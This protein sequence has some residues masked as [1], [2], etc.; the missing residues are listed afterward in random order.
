MK[1]TDLI[2]S[3]GSNVRVAS[4]WIT[5]P[6]AN[7][8]RVAIN[9]FQQFI[10]NVEIPFGKDTGK[11]QESQQE[12]QI[13]GESAHTA[14]TTPAS[15]DNTHI[16][17]INYSTPQENTQK[18]TIYSTETLKQYKSIK[19]R[20]GTYQAI[21][22]FPEILEDGRVRLYEG[23]QI[24]LNKKVLIKEFLLVAPD[25]NDTEANKCQSNFDKLAAINFPNGK[26]QDF[27]LI[28]PLEV[29]SE[30][31]N[32][33]KCCYLITEKI[34]NSKTLR[35]YL[36]E[37]KQLMSTEQVR[38]VLK[39]VLQSLHFLHSKRV[40]VPRE[41]NQEKISQLYH[42]NISL[43]SLLIV[44]NED[45]QDFFIYL[46]DLSLWEDA[47]NPP[48]LAPQTSQ[49]IQT[50]EKLQQG[51]L[52]DLG[53]VCYKLLSGSDREALDTKD[54]NHI[55]D[56]NLSNYIRRLSLANT[57]YRVKDTENEAFQT[58]ETALQTLLKTLPNYRKTEVIQTN[59][60]EESESEL[61]DN[62]NFLPFSM[63]KNA[64]LVAGLASV[65]GFVIS[66]LWLNMRGSVSAGVNITPCQPLKTQEK[67]APYC[68]IS[69]VNLDKEAVKG[70]LPKNFIDSSYGIWSFLMKKPLSLGNTF[71][72]EFQNRVNNNFSITKIHNTSSLDE[73]LK[74][75]D[76]GKPDFIM[77]A[78]PT[79]NMEDYKNKHSNFE[80]KEIAY[81]ALVVLVSFSNSQ[82]RQNKIPPLI[83][84]EKITLDELRSLYTNSS[85]SS[86]A[87]LSRINGSGI[88]LY[89]TR[90]Y[91]DRPQIVE[92]FQNSLLNNKDAP[93]EDKILNK[94][95]GEIYQRELKE[96][97]QKKINLQ[98]K[99]NRFEKILTSDYIFKNIFSDFEDNGV[100]SLG[101]DLLSQVIGQ[102]TVYPLALVNENGQK[103]QLLVENNGN[104]ITPET[105]LCRKGSYRVNIDALK[106]ANYSLGYTIAVVYRQDSENSSGK[107]FADMLRSNEGQSLLKG[108][109]L[110]PIRQIE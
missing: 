54:W 7:I 72:Q 108:A 4:N 67:E 35:E 90:N 75:L 52:R 94:I 61:D 89:L 56:I 84:Q 102:C 46:K 70:K 3:I 69:D 63:I 106:N 41:E 12:S 6:V 49:P 43:D 104:E 13:Q 2:N 76:E 59:A 23:F 97:F 55:K 5:H 66:S 73:S 17:S 57:P 103:V 8:S 93:Q 47:C 95:Q 62:N 37:K 44:Q 65:G 20:K 78:I 74:Q 38:N 71:G 87:N 11:Q 26:G 18:K 100:I 1:L 92:L 109:G 105:D 16:A 27:R 50:S 29:I 91:A 22:E 82:E 96:I 19:G 64:L 32:K 9:R 31:R 80:F 42:G 30:S 40:S 83:F 14:T 88:K 85:G 33:Y 58:A 53:R 48:R 68:R 81:D 24:N 110:V 107:L 36:I 51:D 25:F 98:S 101:V 86:E 45:T 28:T 10:E 77:A 39:Q 15:S 60:I 34:D 99:Q 79:K 21:S